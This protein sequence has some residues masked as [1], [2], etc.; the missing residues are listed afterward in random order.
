MGQVEISVSEGERYPHYYLGVTGDDNSGGRTIF[1][2][3]EE[4]DLL[5]AMRVISWE[6]QNRLSR[7]LE[8]EEK[9][10]AKRRVE[11]GS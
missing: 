3:K 1:V 4:R 6:F 9:Q 7:L 11:K 10:D 5:S 2:D 8:R